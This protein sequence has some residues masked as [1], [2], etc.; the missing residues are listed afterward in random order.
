MDKLLTQLLV[1]NKFIDTNQADDFN[2]FEFI[3]YCST[4]GEIF[5]KLCVGR[6]YHNPSDVKMDILSE[7]GHEY[8]RGHLVVSIEKDEE[9]LYIATCDSCSIDI[10]DD[11]G[12]RFDL[13]VVC[14]LRKRDLLLSFF[15]RQYIAA[16]QIIGEKE[17][18]YIVSGKQHVAV[19][20][21]EVARKQKCDILLDYL[22]EHFS[23]LTVNMRASDIH[24]E[25]NSSDMRMR[26]RVDS[27]LKTI[28]QLDQNLAQTVITNIKLRAK[29][30]FDET[31]LPQDGL[32]K[33][34]FSTH[35]YDVH[36]SII[37][38][39][40]G[41][42]AILCTFNSNSKEFSL[43]NLGLSDSQILCVKN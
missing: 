39:I 30:K 21:I 11:I 41:A 32:L 23:K 29:L 9:D 35:E 27:N 4:K 42:N 6:L 26:F 37:S 1:D 28:Y 25:C 43:H 2:A 3:E 19:E 33:L 12:A 22:F 10:I 14:L 5:E 18:S 38:N 8:V 31:R 15:K 34:S 24:F 16:E 7:L 13:N 20:H 17:Q 40:Y 36:V